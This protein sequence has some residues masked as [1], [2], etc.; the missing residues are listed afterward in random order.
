MR[1]RA[2]LAT[3]TIA[4]PILAVTAVHAGPARDLQR[5][6]LH[7]SAL[8]TAV[9]SWYYEDHWGDLK[10]TGTCAGSSVGP[11]TVEV[12]GEGSL[13]DLTYE[14]FALQLTIRL[15]HLDGRQRIT[16]QTWRCAPVIFCVVHRGSSTW[17]Y[18][19]SVLGFGKAKLGYGD[20]DGPPELVG[21]NLN[22]RFL[23][24]EWR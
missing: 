24:P 18:P 14:D 2:W 21:V 23:S 16:Q 6:L 20:P 13:P 22:W 3:L 1:K 17:P 10:A 7:C 4:V 9:Y 12:T 19:E 8:G 15:V 11:L 5:E